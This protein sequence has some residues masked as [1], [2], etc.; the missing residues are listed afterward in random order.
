MTQHRSK[1][2]ALT[3]TTRKITYLVC[4]AVAIAAGALGIITDGMVANVGAIL[5]GVLAP[6]IALRYTP[7][8]EA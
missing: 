2:E 4:M 8:Q 5:A 6:G 3:P 7:E 1:A